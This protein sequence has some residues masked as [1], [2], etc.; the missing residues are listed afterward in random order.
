MAIKK[1]DFIEIEYVGRLKVNNTIFDL[2]DEKLAKENNL[3]NEDMDYG[4]IIICVG[5]KN[6]INGL[7]KALEGKD[8]N[9]EYNIELKPEESFGKKDAKLI[10]IVSNSV[11]KKQK[12]NV[13]PGLKVNM[14][15][16]IATIRNVSGGRIVVDFNH[17][18]AGRE[19]VYKVKINRI[20]SDDKEKVESILKQ[21]GI[22]KDKIE[23]K[24][25]EVK[26]DAKMPKE[27]QDILE[28]KIKELVKSVKKVIFTVENK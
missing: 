17:P 5:Q 8:I 26:V 2:T 10:K 4:P 18:L 20:V 7:D 15:G 21:L 27:L 14:D 1:G 11:F 19:I 22:K 6:V 12:I 13:F 3:Y 28:K 25:G 24:E 9:K 23:L 16:S